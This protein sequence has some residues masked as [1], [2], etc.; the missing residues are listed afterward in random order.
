MSEM[1]NKLAKEAGIVKDSDHTETMEA[2][3]GRGYVAN[4]K[5]LTEFARLVGQVARADERRK[6]EGPNEA[7]CAEDGRGVRKS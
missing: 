7:P 4:L 5:E 6:Y 3:G 1:I 2:I